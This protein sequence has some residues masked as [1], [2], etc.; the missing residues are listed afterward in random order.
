MNITQL[1][2]AS[3]ITPENNGM[4]NEDNLIYIGALIGFIG[5]LLVLAIHY[6]F[7]KGK[8]QNTEEIL[9]EVAI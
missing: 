3:S 2:L 1:V 8:Q 6:T 5:S 4:L 7:K 9:V